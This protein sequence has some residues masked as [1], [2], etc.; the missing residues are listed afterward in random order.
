MKK[1]IL[2]IVA[3]I[4]LTCFSFSFSSCNED[5]IKAIIDII[6][7]DSTS[8]GS[9]WDRILGN[10]SLKDNDK[11]GYLADMIERYIAAKTSDSTEYL[12]GVWA[13][14]ST[15]GT[16]LDTFWFF[17][18]S[19]VLEH[20]ISTEDTL[21]VQY[22]GGYLYYSSYDQMIVQFNSVYNYL[23]K[24]N[25]DYSEYHIYGVSK[26]AWQAALGMTTLTL[27]DLDTETG[28][29]ISQISY[30]YVEDVE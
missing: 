21:D 24:R 2:A 9:I 14:Q 7:S 23:T 10:D 30:T 3:A 6:G 29:T 17:R 16:E 19:T 8:S 15:D 4:S 11:Y 1:F 18:D 22:S 20:Y 25:F 13:Y 28:E 27:T 12:A 26:P 5:T